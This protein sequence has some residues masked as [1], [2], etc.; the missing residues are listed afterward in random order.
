MDS[1][2]LLKIY[3]GTSIVGAVIPLDEYIFPL[4]TK[5]RFSVSATTDNFLFAGTVKFT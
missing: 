2:F 3:N 1:K 4:I 5:R